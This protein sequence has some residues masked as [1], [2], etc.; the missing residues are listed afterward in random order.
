MIPILF[1]IPYLSFSQES[2]PVQDNLHKF[3]DGFYEKIRHMHNVTSYGRTLDS[4]N[5]TLPTH[6]VIIVIDDGHEDGL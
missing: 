1:C 2:D 5:A 3:D 6:S 4:V